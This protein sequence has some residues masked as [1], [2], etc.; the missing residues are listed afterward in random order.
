ML[1]KWQ[2]SGLSL[3]EFARQEGIPYRKLYYWKEKL[4]HIDR[5]G[6]QKQR[7]KSPLNLAEFARQ[8]GIPYSTLCHWKKMGKVMKV[9]EKATDIRSE[10]EDEDV[11]GKENDLEG[12]MEVVKVANIKVQSLEGEEIGDSSGIHLSMRGVEIF[13]TNDFNSDTLRRVLEVISKT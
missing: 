11:L 3:S 2:A 1:K 7:Q 13:L 5:N 4:G 9:K 10:S 8:E 12:A 6:T